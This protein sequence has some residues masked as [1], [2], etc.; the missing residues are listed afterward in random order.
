VGNAAE[1]PRIHSFGHRS[2][3][4]ND[5]EQ[6]KRF[7]IEVM[8]GEPMERAIRRRLLRFGS[9]AP[10]SACRL[11]AACRPGAMSNIHITPFMRTPKISCR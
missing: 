6:S 2:M 7:F 10:S 11:A 3:P 8:G 1:R 9:P 4:V 5:I